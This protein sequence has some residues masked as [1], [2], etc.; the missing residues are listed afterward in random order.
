M[1]AGFANSEVPL[2]VYYHC[3]RAYH[4]EMG[5]SAA[6]ELEVSAGQ[7]GLGITYGWSCCF[8]QIFS[9]HRPTLSAT[10]ASADIA[11]LLIPRGFPDRT[12]GI[13]FLVLFIPSQKPGFDTS[14]Q[15]FLLQS[16]T[17][18]SRTAS[19][20]AARNPSRWGTR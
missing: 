9:R 14:L 4:R 6:R 15:C 19:P 20:P 16:T 7:C 5:P 13:A 10:T 11:M 3:S 18:P 2:V 1:N 12:I 17:C 8:L